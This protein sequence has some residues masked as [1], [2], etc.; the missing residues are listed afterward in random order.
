MHTTPV[1][2]EAYLTA[3]LHCITQDTLC[4]RACIHI[5]QTF[6][7]IQAQNPKDGGFISYLSYS[8]IHQERGCRLSC[9]TMWT[10]LCNGLLQMLVDNRRIEK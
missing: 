9:G 10:K 6:K 3:L 1:L 8:S 5:H 7:F 4:A 2:L